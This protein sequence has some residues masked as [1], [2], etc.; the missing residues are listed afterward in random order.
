MGGS[1][2]VEALKN[3]INTKKPDILLIEETNMLEDKVMNRSS[4]FWKFSRGEAISSRGAS[5]G[6]ETFNKA[7]KFDIKSIKEN[8]HLLLVEV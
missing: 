1:I 4:L 3:I 2:K 8:T 6:V 5:G 7:Y